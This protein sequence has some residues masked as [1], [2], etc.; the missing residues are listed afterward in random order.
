MYCSLI[1]HYVASR[2]AWV[3]NHLLIPVDQ[4]TLVVT[5]DLSIEI[6]IFILHLM[7][8]CHHLASAFLEFLSPLI[9]V[10]LV[11][12]QH[13]LLPTPRAVIIGSFNKDS[14]LIIET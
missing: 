10:N 12:W 8:K 6:I 13:L 9:L 14:P 1:A 5:L 4:D 11:S 7:V 2:K 3:A